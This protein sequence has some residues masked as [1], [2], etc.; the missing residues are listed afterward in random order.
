MNSKS[1]S[2]I[3]LVSALGLAGC[4]SKSEKLLED[5]N[6]TSPQIESPVR[7]APNYSFDTFG[8]KNQPYN[9]GVN[10]NKFCGMTSGDFDGDGD[11]DIAIMDLYGNLQI[12]DNK[13]PQKNK[14]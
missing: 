8:E 11:I 9:G 10:Y 7:K 12:Y 4:Q 5:R 2:T 14:Q 1:L 13:M 6:T 3:V